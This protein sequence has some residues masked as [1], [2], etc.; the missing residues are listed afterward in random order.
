TFLWSGVVL[1]QHDHD[2]LRPV[3]DVGLVQDALGRRIDLAMHPRL[4]ALMSRREITRLEVG[5]NL[6]DTY[7]C[8]LDDSLG[9]PL[10]V[11]DCMG[12]SLHVEGELWG[13]LT[14]DALEEGTFD[15]GARQKLQRLLPLIEGLLR[16]TRLEQENRAL[17]MVRADE[18]RALPGIK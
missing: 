18:Q 10:P 1:L 9:E 11:H 4:A 16:V 8:L 14:L 3:P 17:R 5:S 7:D 13:V 15:E 6:P 2:E 12:V